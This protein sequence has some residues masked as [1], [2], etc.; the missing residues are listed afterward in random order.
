[1]TT[2][3]SFLNPQFT[4]VNGKL[5]FNGQDFMGKALDH[6][7]Y[8]RWNKPAGRYQPQLDAIVSGRTDRLTT[9]R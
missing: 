5:L 3:A 8:E 9:A 7:R 1:V 6:G 2:G 4:V